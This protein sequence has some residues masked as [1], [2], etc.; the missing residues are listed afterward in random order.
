MHAAWPIR[1]ICFAGRC[2]CGGTSRA[3]R[4]TASLPRASGVGRTSLRSAVVAS[5]P[6]R[7]ALRFGHKGFDWRG[8]SIMSGFD[9]R[10]P[11]LPSCRNTIR[12][13]CLPSPHVGIPSGLCAFPPLMSEYHQE[14]VPSLP[15]RL[16]ATRSLCLRNMSCAATPPAPRTAAALATA[17]MT[18]G[19]ATAQRGLAGR[20]ADHPGRGSAG[21]WERTSGTSGIKRIRLGRTRD[22]QVMRAPREGFSSS[23]DW[24]SEG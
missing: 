12:C 6:R 23:R 19:P 13:L 3:L 24:I 4:S 11:S 18:L 14:S 22:A 10:L 15:S 2:R 9:N 21:K 17:T 16:N 1:N 8:R 7:A 20:T 5:Q